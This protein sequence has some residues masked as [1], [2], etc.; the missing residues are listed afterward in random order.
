MIE[1]SGAVTK[2]VTVPLADL[3]TLPR[4]E[5]IADFHCVAG[6]TAT[7]LHWEGVSFV[8]FYRRVVEPL[9]RPDTSI[10]H[11]IFGGL[12]GFQSVVSIEDALA[13][14]VLIAERLDGQLLD[15][16]HGAPARLVSPDQ[17][18]YINTKH[19]CHIELHTARPTKSLGA[20]H[21][22]SQAM[23]RG[24]LV[25]R[26]PRARVWEEERHPFLPARLL[27]SFYR[28]FIPPGVYLSARG[29]RRS[30]TP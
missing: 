7:N 2:P 23:L 20:A 4:R 25:M 3:A 29:S 17:Y 22:I 14:D 30:R 10:T 16:D 9:V 11:I 21:P 1:V 6:W 19:L 5:M 26:H 27:R 15:G 18:G 8:T 13:D 28:L 12:D 24:P